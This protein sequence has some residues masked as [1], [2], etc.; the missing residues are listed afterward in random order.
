MSLGEGKDAGLVQGQKV[1]C[2]DNDSRTNDVTLQRN[3]RLNLN[4]NP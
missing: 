2:K 1:R 4:P 3:W